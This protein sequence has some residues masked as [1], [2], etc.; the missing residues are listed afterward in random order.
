MAELKKHLQML[1]GKRHDLI[2]A[3]AVVK[4]GVTIFQHE[5][6]AHMAMRDFPDAFIDEYLAREGEKLLSCVGGYQIE[7]AGRELFETIDGD[8]YT[9]MGMPLGHL[10]TFLR[11]EKI[12]A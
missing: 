9:I 4:N 10:L 5:D 2:S 7:G 1:R 11:L 6:T 3:V 8:Y 12:I